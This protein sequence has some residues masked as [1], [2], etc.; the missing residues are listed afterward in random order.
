M[1]FINEDKLPVEIKNN[2]LP[3]DNTKAYK[4]TLSNI[5]KNNNILTKHKLNIPFVLKLLNKYVN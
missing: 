3:E 2:K 4:Y 5:I 1:N